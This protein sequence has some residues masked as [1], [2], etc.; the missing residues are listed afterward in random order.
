MLFKR[1]S[2][3]PPLAH[4]FGKLGMCLLFSATGVLGLFVL[5]V[6]VGGAHLDLSV[7]GRLFVTLVAGALP[8]GALGLALGYSAGPNSAPALANLVYLPMA[9][10][11]GL[12][13]PVQVLPTFLQKIAPFLP[14]YHLAQLGLRILGMGQGV[15]VARSVSY[16]AAF[17]V[18]ALGFAWAGYR[19][20][21]GK[22]FG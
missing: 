8:F 1:A 18:A 3:M 10:C 5:G 22:T 19:R 9:I 2:P 16:L 15:P 7:L 21:E 11:S 12:W 20:D 4:L 17:T 13:F 14:A 6:T